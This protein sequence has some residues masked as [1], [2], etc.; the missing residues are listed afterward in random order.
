MAVRSSRR[1]ASSRAD[2]AAPFR[3]RNPS[4]TKRPVGNPLSTSAAIAADGPGAISTRW[5]AVDAARTRRH[6]VEH[7]QLLVAERDVDGKAHGEGVHG[8]SGTQQQRAVDALA[9][10]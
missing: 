7:V 9:T 5:P 1:S 3:G 8:T 10:Q 6:D 2:R 4:N